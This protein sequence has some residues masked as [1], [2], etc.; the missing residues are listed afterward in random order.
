MPSTN[1][2]GNEKAEK[3]IPTI[4]QPLDGKK[5]E[6][7]L[8]D[9]FFMIAMVLIAALISPL[10]AEDFL[11]DFSRLVCDIASTSFN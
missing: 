3:P 2:S 8:P 1:G 9:W 6:S 4:A 10:T 11:L 7:W 5:P